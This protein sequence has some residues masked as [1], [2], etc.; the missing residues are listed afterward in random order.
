MP[1][2]LSS[3]CVTGQV[4]A[5]HAVMTAKQLQMR[6]LE[7]SFWCS[8]CKSAHQCGREGLWLEGPEALKPKQARKVEAENAPESEYKHKD[9]NPIPQKMRFLGLRLR[10]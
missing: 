4:V 10:S 8:F 2:V 5:T 1:R 9:P 3:C 6:G 7:L